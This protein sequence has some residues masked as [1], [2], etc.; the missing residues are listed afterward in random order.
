MSSEPSETE[1]DRELR[2]MLVASAEAAPA[3][4]HRRGAVAGSIA[5]FAL[6]GLLT[7]GAVSAAALNAPGGTSTVSIEQM[8]VALVQDDTQLFGTPF[9]LSGQGDTTVE[10]GPAPVGAVDLVVAFH[11]EDA[12]TYN[13]TIDGEAASTTICDQEAT[14]YPNG[15]EFYPITD[16]DPHT[17]TVTTAK[18]NHFVLWASWAS[19]AAVPEPSDAQAAAMADGAVTEAEYRDGFTRY[20]QCMRDAGYSLI[21]VDDGGTIITYSSPAQGTV[22]GAEGRCY[23]EEFGQLDAAWQIA[24]EYDSDTQQ[25]LR[26]CLEEAGI[27]PAHDVAGVNMQL[28]ENS[29]DPIKCITG[30]DPPKTPSP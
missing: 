3:L 25:A 21:R 12:G 18:A 23:A 16:S 17:L 27:T 5:A 20:R 7:G 22:S 6:A 1:R 26:G 9:I 14:D 24:N 30:E 15:G 8:T 29:I 13:M 10:L 4:P 2:R 11:C 19:R 28:K